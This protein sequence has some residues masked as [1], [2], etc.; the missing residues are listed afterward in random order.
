[1]RNQSLFMKRTT[2]LAMALMF[3]FATSVKHV[4]AATPDLTSAQMESAIEE[5]F[6]GFVAIDAQ[7]ALSNFADHAALEDPVG[8]PAMQGKPA[9]AAYLQTF[10]TL[11]NQIKLYSLE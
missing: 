5:V 1:M 3:L 7:R 8:T 6:A 2:A 10:P 4:H 9:I 11:F